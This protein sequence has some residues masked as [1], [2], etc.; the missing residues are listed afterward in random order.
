MKKSSWCEKHLKIRRVVCELQNRS[1]HFNRTALYPLIS[2]FRRCGLRSNL[3][4]CISL[5][6]W[7]ILVV[8]KRVSTLCVCCAWAR[9]KD[10]G[11]LTTSLFSPSV[12]QKSLLS[13]GCFLRIGM[14]IEDTFLRGRAAQ[15]NI[16]L[17]IQYQ[18]LYLPSW[19][20]HYQLFSRGL[21]KVVIST[22]LFKISPININRSYQPVY[23]QNWDQL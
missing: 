18:L 3:L 11:L 1:S 14:D 21:I 23:Y 7:T 4:K 9:L 5:L 13:L 12:R 2:F 19:Q 17:S 16:S 8:E 22:Q 15:I 6:G 20:Y 10:L